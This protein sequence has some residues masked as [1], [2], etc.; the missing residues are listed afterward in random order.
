MKTK[1]KTTKKGNMIRFFDG[2]RN[3]VRWDAHLSKLEKHTP[4]D[5]RRFGLLV[6]FS[7]F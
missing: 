1:Y 6:A 7:F 4:G 3:R 2:E 5:A